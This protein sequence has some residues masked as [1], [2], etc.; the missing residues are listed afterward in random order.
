MLQPHWTITY[1]FL[2]IFVFSL[3]LLHLNSG[4]Y[5]ETE[6]QNAH[7]FVKRSRLAY[8]LLLIREGHTVITCYADAPV[9]L[10]RRNKK[11]KND[12][13]IFGKKKKKWQD[14]ES[15]SRN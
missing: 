11:K 15:E 6:Q 7:V 14:I 13:Q 5:I 2:H 9:S 1:A 10:C 4:D 12:Q 3:I 8:L